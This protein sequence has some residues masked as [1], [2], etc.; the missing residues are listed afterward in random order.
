M[1][2]AETSPIVIASWI[3]PHEIVIQVHNDGPLIPAAKIP[4]I[5]DFSAQRPPGNK[6]APPELPHLGI[7][8]YITSN[9]VGA[10]AG[11]I[12]LTSTAQDGTTF[13]VRLPC[14]TA[15]HQPA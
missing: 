9:I 5:F 14:V 7:G 12:S 15:E 6:A 10:H 11:K 2:V 8:L 4:T 3:E 1:E 13:E